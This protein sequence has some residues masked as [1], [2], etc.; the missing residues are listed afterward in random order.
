M[1]RNYRLI[2]EDLK[3]ILKQPDMYFRS[4]TQDFYCLHYFF[5]MNL[6]LP[7]APIPSDSA[8]L[9]SDNS[10]SPHPLYH[11]F[12][13]CVSTH[14]GDV[15]DGAKELVSHTSGCPSICPALA[16]HLVPGRPSPCWL[17]P[18]SQV[19]VPPALAFS[20]LFQGHSFHAAALAVTWGAPSGNVQL[21]TLHPAPWT[22][23]EV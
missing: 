21:F 23:C 12:P 1:K 18:Q 20:R 19:K 17:T 13:W 6:I 11:F 10:S 4:Q 14:W 5:L 2:S 9:I 3:Y 7:G 22:P 8:N 15:L 16:S